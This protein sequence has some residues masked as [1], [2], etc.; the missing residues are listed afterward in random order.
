MLSSSVILVFKAIPYSRLNY[1]NSA[2]SAAS[3]KECML[4]YIHAFKHLFMIACA[5]ALSNSPRSA[6]R[7]LG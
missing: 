6:S 1:F 3:M 2:L 7:F 4:Y 5:P